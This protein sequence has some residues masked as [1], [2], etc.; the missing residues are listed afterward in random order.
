MKYCKR[1]GTQLDDD[2][3]FCTACGTKYEENETVPIK[4]EPDENKSKKTSKSK[5][6]IILIAIAV[7]LIALGSIGYF[8][9][10]PQ[11][12]QYIQEQE[13]QEKA[14]RVINQIN[15]VTSGEITLDSEKD[16]D[17]AKTEY[18]SLNDDQKAL[19]DNYGKLEEAYT[20]LDGLKVEQENQEKAQSVID[21]IEAVD[22]E[23]LTDSDTSI[24]DIRDQYDSLTEDQKKLVTN[25]DKLAEY[26]GIVQ[27]KKEEKAEEEA[28]DQAESSSREEINDMFVNLVEYE[29]VWGDFGSHVDKYQGMVESVI[30]SHISLSDYFGG[31]VN[32][33]YMY[34]YRQ[35]PSTYFIR[36][37]GPSP[38]GA[39]Q[40]RTYDCTVLPN[41]SG[42]ELQFFEGGYY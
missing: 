20:T 16:L 28:Q 3:L 8:V 4:N 32:E 10:Y 26:E 5:K 42:T 19:V 27:E 33:V 22:S 15:S 31:D 34:L 30:K 39:G 23:S 37:E 12:T 14:D 40:F 24:Q 1:C 21:A 11:V 35:G 41:D 25:A 38:S 9:I 29:G 17:S 36:F 2:E 6:P 13:N 7:C 18:N